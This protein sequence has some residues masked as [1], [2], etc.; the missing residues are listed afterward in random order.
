MQVG[1]LCQKVG[2][3]VIRMLQVGGSYGLIVGWQGW[4]WLKGLLFGDD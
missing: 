3:V 2:V 1:A 4:W